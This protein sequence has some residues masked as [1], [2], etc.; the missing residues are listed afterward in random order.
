MCKINELDCFFCEGRDARNENSERSD[1]P[2]AD[3]SDGEFGWLFGWDT[4]DKHFLDNVIKT[5]RIADDA[6]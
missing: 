3:G 1:C 6:N 2:Y 5:D 4:A